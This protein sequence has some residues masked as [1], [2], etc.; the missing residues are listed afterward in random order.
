MLLAA[1]NSGTIGNSRTIGNS[2]AVDP[3]KNYSEAIACYLKP[4]LGEESLHLWCA[5][6]PPFCCAD[7]SRRAASRRRR[8]KRSCRMR[9]SNAWARRASGMVCSGTRWSLRSAARDLW[10]TIWSSTISPRAACS[11]TT[12]ANWGYDFSPGGLFKDNKGKLGMLCVALTLL[13]SELSSKP[14]EH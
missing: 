14:W 8:A 11:R 1:S 7:A 2:V 3:L 5:H 6:A 12:G 10:S 9:S 13:I 4:W